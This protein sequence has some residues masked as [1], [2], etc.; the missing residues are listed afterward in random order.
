[1]PSE[2]CK[3]DDVPQPSSALHPLGALATS[4]GDVV[5]SLAAALKVS[6]NARGTGEHL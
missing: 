6:P 2:S 4:F 5:Q 3:G 1:M